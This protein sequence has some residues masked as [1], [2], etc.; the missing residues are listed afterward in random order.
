MYKLCVSIHLIKEP[1]ADPSSGAFGA[2]SGD[3]VKRDGDAVERMA[4]AAERLLSSGG[5][6]IFPPAPPSIVLQSAQTY[7]VLA[8]SYSE[9]LEIL[10]KFDALARNIGMPAERGV[11]RGGLGSVVS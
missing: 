11:S 3:P 9:A 6:S 4:T 1:E 5:V 8:A 2:P 10:T 7:D